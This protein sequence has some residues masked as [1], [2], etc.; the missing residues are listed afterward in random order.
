MQKLDPAA[1]RAAAADIAAFK[2][3]FPRGSLSPTDTL[4]VDLDARMAVV[5][6]CLNVRVLGANGACYASMRC[7]FLVF[8]VTTKA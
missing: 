5:I 7:F 8:F 2:Q 4:T 3:L 6:L 1:Q